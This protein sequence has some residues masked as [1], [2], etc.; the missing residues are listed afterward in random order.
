MRNVFR[1][2]AIS[3]ER[4][5]WPSPGRSATFVHPALPVSEGTTVKLRSL[6]KP[7]SL[8]AAILCAASVSRVQA[9]GVLPPEAAAQAQALVQQSGMTQAQ[10]QEKLREASVSDAHGATDAAPARRKVQAAT[11]SN[12]PA[13]KPD[14][15]APNVRPL[16]DANEPFGFE[17]FHYSPTTFEPLA[18]GPVDE[19]YPLG[20]GDEVSLTLWG[21]DQ[22]SLTLSVSREGVIT[23]PDVGQVSVNGLT[24][25]QAQAR[26]RSA[27]GKVYS[28]LRPAG[29][30]STTSLRLSL[31]RLRSIQVFL[32]GQVVR[33]GGYTISSVSRVLN[34]LYAAGGPQRDGSLR[35]VRI[36]RGNKLV[37]SVDLY[38]VILGTPGPEMP[39][40]ENGDV[41]FVPA[42][43]RRVRLAG[44]VRRAG[45][46][47][48][49]DGEQLRSLMEIAGG[50]LPEADLSSA[51][52]D[53]VVPL[54]MRDSLR[55]QGRISVDVN[56]SQVLS[57]ASQD[58]ALTDGDSLCLRALPQRRANVV[59]IT[60]RGVTHA[61]QYQF[62][63]GMRVSDVLAAAGG[64]TPEAYLEHAL[65]TRTLPD[66]TRMMLRF[67]PA[68]ALAHETSDDIELSAMDDLSVRSLW[69]LNDRQSVTVHGLVH[70]PGTYELLQGMTLSDVLMRAGGFTDDAFAVRAEVA[71]VTAGGQKADTLEVPVSRD[72]SAASAS[73]TFMLQPNDA[74]FIRRDPLY[75]QQMFVVLDGEVRFP[76]TYALTRRDERVADLVRRA[77]GLSDQAYPRGSRFHRTGGA[78]LAIDLPRAIKDARCLDNLVMMPGDTLVIPRYMPTVRIEGAVFAPVTALYT[79]GAGINYYVTQASG[80][81]QDADRRG[82]VVVSPAGQVQ[83]GG[84]PEPGSR[85]VVPARPA[86]DTRDHLKDFA[87]LMSVLASAATTFF[88]IHQTTK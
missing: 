25:E 44:P 71:R 13:I 37:A 26:V 11:E 2:H 29:Q 66:S 27:L 84:R 43:A 72:L 82:V 17:I 36:L 86:S 85:I 49:R 52:I 33:P 42:A 88:L 46:Y 77:G 54:A 34:A 15:L 50:V 73:T 12:P 16:A 30:R 53:R 28:G 76:G 4:T 74:V 21:D 24:L 59:T 51:Q 8:L 22:L 69:D 9:Q 60:G 6:I 40:L 38:H 7:A 61:G 68:R 63:P 78:E 10:I 3:R 65:I 81:R 35:D 18:Y 31:G 57:D 14:S 32:L 70:S 80:F 58:V 1:A 19:E 48:L 75:T 83:R 79:P 56:L 20:P 23:L 45:F 55:G 64:T 67:S 41:I 39:R 47:E 62:R 5:A 87:T